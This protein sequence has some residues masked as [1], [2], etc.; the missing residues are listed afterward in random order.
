M[1]EITIDTLEQHCCVW[2]AQDILLDWHCVF[3]CIHAF[4]SLM[5]FAHD[6]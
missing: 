5:R 4:G 6:R 3:L 1:I 2:Y